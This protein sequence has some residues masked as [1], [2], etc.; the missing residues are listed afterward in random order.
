MKLGRLRPSSLSR[1]RVELTLTDVEKTGAVRTFFT[2]VKEELEYIPAQLNVLEYWQEKAVFSGVNGDDYIIAAQ[3]PIHPLGKCFASTP[4]LANIMVSKYADGLPLY[5]QE[6]ILKRSGHTVSRSNTEF[7]KI[8]VHI[9]A[10]FFLPF[11]RF[12]RSRRLGSAIHL[13]WRL[14][15]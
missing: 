3:R 9:T 2:K 13:Q 15:A 14:S 8:V 4:L 11:D 10:L 6:S 7:C 1:V 5:R 12:Q